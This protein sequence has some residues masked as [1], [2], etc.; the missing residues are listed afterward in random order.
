MPVSS[1]SK[2]ALIALAIA[3]FLVCIQP[4]QVSAKFL[5]QKKFIAQG[6]HI[7]EKTICNDVDQRAQVI[8]TRLDD[9]N[10]EAAI[11]CNTRKQTCPEGIMMC[12]HGQFQCVCRN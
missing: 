8:L 10:N 6:T 12:S 1:T 9:D 2:F 11:L 7:D 4:A 5:G 3:V